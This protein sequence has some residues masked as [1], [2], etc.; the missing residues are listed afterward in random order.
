MPYSSNPLMYPP[1]L[2]TLIELL[3]RTQKDAIL[4]PVGTRNEAM[5]KRTQIQ[6]FF[7]ALGKHAKAYR[8]LAE[9]TN[10]KRIKAA[11]LAAP[12]KDHTAPPQARA[13]V[14][15]SIEEDS[16][17]A[18]A[19]AGMWESRYETAMAWMVRSKETPEGWCVE[20]A[21]RTLGDF[22]TKMLAAFD[23]P[24]VENGSPSTAQGNGAAA[25]GIARPRCDAPAG[26]E[27]AI[28]PKQALVTEGIT[29]PV[30]TSVEAMLAKARQ[31]LQEKINNGEL[32]R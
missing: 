4:I 21:K 2:L 30:E 25:A 15:R 14:I 23:L 18:A 11:Q 5:A 32:P 3:D 27:S 28:P 1:E 6:A 7:S 26:N 20:L 13:K 19:L 24:A 17:D 29:A 9:R 16:Q 10:D 12:T 8:A 31:E 22:G